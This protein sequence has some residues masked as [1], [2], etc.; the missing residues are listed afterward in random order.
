MYDD[1]D[2]LYPVQIPVPINL[3]VLLSNESTKVEEVLHQDIT[4]RLFRT[5]EPSL[6]AFL[7]NKIDRLLEL[8]FDANAD[9]ETSAK[10][11]AILEHSQET[12]TAALLAKQRL[13]NTAC[14]VLTKTESTNTLYLNRLASLTLSAIYIDPEAFIAS[15]GFILQLIQFCAEPSILSLFESICMPTDDNDNVDI[16]KWL[17][18]IG[19]PD[20]LQRELD[21]FPSQMEEATLL[22]PKANYYNSLLRIVA[23]CGSSP[24]LG[25][26]VCTYAFVT[27]LNQNAGNYPQFIENSRW[28]AI[29]AIYC[30]DTEE[31]MRG[32]FP[33][34]VEI[35]SDEARV[36]TRACTAAIDLLTVIVKY[37]TVLVDF[38]ISMHVPHIIINNVLNHPNATLLHISAIDFIEEII[39]NDKIRGKF[40]DELMEI[41]LLAFQQENKCLRRTLYKIIKI[42]IKYCKMN[43]KI[44][45]DF[46]NNQRFTEMLKT[47][48]IHY[49]QVLKSQYGGSFR[50]SV[51]DDVTMLAQRAMNN[52]G[53]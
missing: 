12:I 47:K 7:V 23:V 37:D 16:Q 42:V 48:L 39:Q 9:P 14:S 40:A 51:S 1:G 17:V 18:S 2:R 21:D 22:N 11:F 36:L 43:S 27:A 13:H 45:F 24:I 34:A 44:A 32:F 6:I 52:Y 3:K 20:I 49:R 46:R 41:L 38:I 30:P 19:F 53:V 50:Y 25:P 10:A 31:T 26:K 15:C 4:F 5:S 28:E 8:S 29:S 35:I 33:L